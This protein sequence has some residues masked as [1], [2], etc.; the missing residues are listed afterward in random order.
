MIAQINVNK[1]F[2]YSTTP[3]L[4]PTCTRGK[5]M[6]AP[7]GAVQNRVSLFSSASY[8]QNLNALRTKNNG[9]K[10]ILEDIRGPDEKTTVNCHMCSY[11]RMCRT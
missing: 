2:H 5:S 8:L 4:Q 1:S 9:E 10:T 6:R 3:S 7:Q 11:C